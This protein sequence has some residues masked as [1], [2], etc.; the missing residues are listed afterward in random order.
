L[1]ANL[2]TPGTVIGTL[3][4]YRGALAAR[5]AEFRAAP[6]GAPPHAPVLYVKPANTW[7]G[8]G[9]AIPLPADVEAVEA[10][11]SL[12][13]A[14]G[15]VA[16]RVPAARALDVVAGYAIVNDVCVPHAS[17]FRPAIRQRCRDGFCAIG[18]TLA[19]DDSPHALGV[20]VFVNHRLAA[21][22]TTANLVRPVAQLVAD[23]TEFMT[24]SPGDLL[25]TG[26]PEGMPLLYAGDRVC[27]EIDGLEGGTYKHNN[28]HAR[29]KKR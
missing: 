10:G 21:E 8:G 17:V 22:N 25:L 4:N 26:V 15:A 19:R 12:A 14:I 7:I 28:I 6:Y 11:A 27:V 5:A 24:L 9:D 13:I 2:P 3:L 29:F 20:R 18:P 1:R 16:T 23:V